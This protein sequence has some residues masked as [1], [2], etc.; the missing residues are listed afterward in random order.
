MRVCVCA[1]VCVS[2]GGVYVSVCIYVCVFLR[3]GGGGNIRS[4]TNV[5]RRFKCR[6]QGCLL[7]S[8]A[9]LKCTFIPD[10]VP[11]RIEE[12]KHRSVLGIK[13]KLEQEATDSAYE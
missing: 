9:A 8:R 10:I 2:Q 3:E 5:L 11:L 12:N 7:N 4:A 1:C 6:G 13:D